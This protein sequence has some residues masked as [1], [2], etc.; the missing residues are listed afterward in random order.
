LYLKKSP[1]PQQSHFQVAAM[2]MWK[3]ANLTSPPLHQQAHLPTLLT[4]QPA[5]DPNRLMDTSGVAKTQMRVVFALKYL[6]VL[7]QGFA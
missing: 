1:L 7:H 6:V 4:G 2:N 5:D 3:R